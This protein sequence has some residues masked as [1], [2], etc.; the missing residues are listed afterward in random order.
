MPYSDPEKQREY[1]RRWDKAHRPARSWDFLRAK[2]AERLDRQ[3]A[4]SLDPD[5]RED[6]QRENA[7]FDEETS[8]SL[9]LS[10]QRKRL[11]L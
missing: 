6:R 2:E 1:R 10:Q 4:E 3:I 8:F 11:G 9:S 7:S 5:S